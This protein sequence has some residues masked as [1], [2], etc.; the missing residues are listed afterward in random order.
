MEALPELVEKTADSHSDYERPLIREF[1][2]TIVKLR[3]L[4]GKIAEEGF[5]SSGNYRDSILWFNVNGW[6]IN[7]FVNCDKSES[8]SQV[9]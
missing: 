1:E 3:D 9:V 5:S 8:A 6:D 2:E 4:A 7:I